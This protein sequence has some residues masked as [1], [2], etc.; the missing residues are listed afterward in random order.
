MKQALKFLSLNR[1]FI[2]L[3]ILLVSLPVLL[4]LSQNPQIFHSQAGPNDPEISSIRLDPVG[5]VTG[6]QTS[7][8]PPNQSV[9]AVV[10]FKLSTTKHFDAYRMDATEV[11]DSP[12]FASV[13]HD[14]G[15]QGQTTNIV[16]FTTP[17]TPG[18]YYFIVNAHSRP[19]HSNDDWNQGASSPDTGCAWDSKI[20]Q[21]PPPLH[22]S[23]LPCINDG[24][25]TF[26]VG[27]A[28]TASTT[29]SVSPSATITPTPVTTIAPRPSRS[30]IPLPANLAATCIQT[31]FSC[32]AKDP[33]QFTGALYSI[34][35]GLVGGVGI[36]FMII[37]AYMVLSSQG[38]PTKVAKGREY[39]T[40]SIIGILLAL[41]GYAFYQ[42]IAVDIL[43]LP[44]FSK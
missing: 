3:G 12:N 22:D 15:L 2:I 19:D 9:Q 25:K 41:F 36:L 26:W 30:P 13:Y 20:Y 18:K 16:N 5:T 21:G 11:G 35:L 17:V 10:I 38:D 37:G 39:I 7:P 32:L 34:G 4:I 31:D 6:S 8:Y 1:N 14:I 33:I 40:Y 24:L 28:T 29:P 27:V 43:K 44:G 23:G 42:I